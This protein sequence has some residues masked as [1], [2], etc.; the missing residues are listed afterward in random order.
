MHLCAP[1]I[2]SVAESYTS[3]G[4]IFITDSVIFAF[5][6]KGS[7]DMILIVAYLVG[8]LLCSVYV[9]GDVCSPYF[10]VCDSLRLKGG[11]RLYS[12]HCQLSGW[13]IQLCMLSSHTR[14]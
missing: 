2:P 6:N 9:D 11:I 7:T 5:K 10:P 14:R 4:M 12:Y 1:E 3:D 13:H 8:V